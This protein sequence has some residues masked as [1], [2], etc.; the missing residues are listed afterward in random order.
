MIV[1]VITKS[2]WGDYGYEI[3]DKVF[4]SEQEAL[5]FMNQEHHRHDSYECYAV[6]VVDA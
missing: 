4:I 3:P 5:N 6:E 1:Y 2:S